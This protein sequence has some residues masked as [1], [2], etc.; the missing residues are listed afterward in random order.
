MSSLD[1]KC[2]LT[3]LYGD[4]VFL[5]E[6]EATALTN[7]ILPPDGQEYGLSA[8]DFKSA[9]LDDTAVYLRTGS[10]IAETRVVL[11]KNLQELKADPQ[12]QLA[13]WVVDLPLATHVILTAIVSRQ[14]AQKGNP[15]R[16]A[17]K[18]VIEANGQSASFI[19]PYERELAQWV[20]AEAQGL[21]KGMDR[22][23]AEALV[24]MAGR[25]HGRLV[26]EVRKLVTY[27]GDAPL[28][29][30]QDV[31]EVAVRTAEATVFQLVDAIAEG[32][33]KTALDVLPELVPAHGS[34]SAAIPLLGMLARNLR[35]LWQASHL[36][37]NGAS[38]DR[39]GAIAPELADLL[40]NEHNVVQASRSSFVAKKLARHARS[41]TDKQAADS[42]ERVLHADRTLKGQT[43]EYMDARLVVERLV[44]ELCL[45]SRQPQSQ[46]RRR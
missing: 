2:P 7:A 33:A 14:V 22:R 30:P 27:V 18:K 37:R 29:S 6:R 13:A 43:D 9:S 46:G 35:L 10:L 26:S 41:F 5:I 31:N 28:I 42:L 32:N 21:G 45:L 12:K 36:A 17:L 19:T 4:S 25:D 40:P 16:A 11:L 15:A 3:L 38:I 24:E 34:V 39:R 20:C 23:A 44:I 1:P 8:L